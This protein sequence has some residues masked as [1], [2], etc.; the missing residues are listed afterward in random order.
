MWWCKRNDV[1]WKFARQVR[2]TVNIGDG[3]ECEAAENDRRRMI[4]GRKRRSGASMSFVCH[5]GLTLEIA[6]L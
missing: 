6:E 5:S 3:C 4:S 1:K 2:L